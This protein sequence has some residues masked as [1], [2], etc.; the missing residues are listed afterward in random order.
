MC[1]RLKKYNDIFESFISWSTSQFL[2]DFSFS[3]TIW[4]HEKKLWQWRNHFGENVVF[5]VRPY[6]N[7]RR[8]KYMAVECMCREGGGRRSPPMHISTNVLS[9]WRGNP[10]PVFSY[11][12]SSLFFFT[13]SFLCRRRDANKIE[14]ITN[15]NIVKAC[16]YDQF[17]LSKLFF[18]HFLLTWPPACKEI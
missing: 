6:Q 5:Q 1:K 7:T 4:K 11:L 2:N 14:M 18:I 16:Q 8:V 13:S 17:V 9:V 15:M 12:L 10:R 3:F